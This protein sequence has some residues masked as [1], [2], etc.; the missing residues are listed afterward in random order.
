MNDK[1]RFMKKINLAFQKITA[2]N[3]YPKQT[4]TTISTAVI[5]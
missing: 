2:K 1:S 5:R 4:K 3:I